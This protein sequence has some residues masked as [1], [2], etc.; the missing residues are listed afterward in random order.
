MVKLISKASAILEKTCNEYRPNVITEYINELAHAFA[1]F[2]ELSPV[3][4]AESEE[5]K[6]ARLVLVSAFRHTVKGMLNVLG[7]EPLERM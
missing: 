4:K 5:T 2:Y 1:K 7:I 6:A 3:L